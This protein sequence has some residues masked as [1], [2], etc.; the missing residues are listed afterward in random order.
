[1]PR[2]LQ[3]GFASSEL[4]C[5]VQLCG[6]GQACGDGTSIHLWGDCSR[7]TCRLATPNGQYDFSMWCVMYNRGM[8]QHFF[9]RALKNVLTLAALQSEP[10]DHQ[11]ASSR[12]KPCWRS[13][14]EYDKGN[15]MHLTW[16]AHHCTEFQ[17][18]MGN[19]KYRSTAIKAVHCPTLR[20]WLW[21]RIEL[22]I[23]HAGLLPP[24]CRRVLGAYAF[25]CLTTY[26]PEGPVFSA[27]NSEHCDVVTTTMP[28]SHEN[29][30]RVKTKVLDIAW[31]WL[32]FG[33]NNSSTGVDFRAI[34]VIAM[35]LVLLMR[36]QVCIGI[37]IE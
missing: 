8:P 3:S 24:C 7:L 21:I 17:G 10:S 28:H 14:Y 19:P 33:D 22:L 37:L 6:A 11:E 2:L 27:N 36:S 18:D 30:R 9:C 16:A 25:T 35:L 26:I 1:M 13:V 5:K 23:T 29:V 31:I 4:W 12:F 20:Y 34:T 32:D 15:E